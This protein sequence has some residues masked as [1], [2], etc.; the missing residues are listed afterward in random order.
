VPYGGGAPAVTAL[1]AGVRKRGLPE[2]QPAR[3]HAA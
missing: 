1:V 3:D 2:R